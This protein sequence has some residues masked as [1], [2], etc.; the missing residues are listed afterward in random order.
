MNPLRSLVA[1]ACLGLAMPSAAIA[2]PP[3][4]QA[5][6]GTVEGQKDGAIRVFKGIPYALPP[7]GARRWRPPSPMPRW[8]GVRPANAYGAACVQPPPL[9][10]GTYARSAMPLS[11]DCLT[12]NIWAP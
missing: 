9:L 1:L 6:A 2:S 5:P 3:R 7:V 11:E 4:V 10:S 8:Q 12:L